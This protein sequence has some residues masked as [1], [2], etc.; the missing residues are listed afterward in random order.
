MTNLGEHLWQKERIMEEIPGRGIN[1]KRISMEDKLKIL[2]ISDHEFEFFFQLFVQNVQRYL[3]KKE[4]EDWQ[5][6]KSKTGRVLRLDKNVVAYHLM[7]R[8]WVAT[9]APEVSHHLCIDIDASRNF[10]FVYN[11]V[12]EWIP[13]S[14][15][16]MSSDRK[17]V[18]VYAFIHPDFPIRSDK[19]LSIT[20]MELKMRGI[21]TDPGI[22]E[23]FPSPKRFLRLPLGKGSCLVDPKTLVPLNLTLAD[24]IRF[25]KEN[26]WRHGFEELFPGLYRR[27]GRPNVKL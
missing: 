18:H 17:G 10:S 24:S 21:E 27:I 11:T 2:D 4:G 3:I 6:A 1:H 9:F 5:V 19:L 16:I 8:Y 23:I 26:I 25:I 22:C 12:R 7:Q 20:S 15:V 13:R 14:I